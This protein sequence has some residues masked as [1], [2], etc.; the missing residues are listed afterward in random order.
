MSGKINFNFNFHFA[1]KRCLFKIL[2]S[3]LVCHHLTTNIECY[4]FR[5]EF[6]HI[7]A[8]TSKIVIPSLLKKLNY[9]TSIS[10]RIA[11]DLYTTSVYVTSPPGF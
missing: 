9:K 6:F 8:D 5:G 11:R 1:F 4:K 3:C 2:L 7:L 10:F